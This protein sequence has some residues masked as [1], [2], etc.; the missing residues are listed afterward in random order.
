M[1][2]TVV[3]P[4]GNDSSAGLIVGLVLAAIIIAAAIFLALPYLRDMQKPQEQQP[5]KIDVTI[6][7]PTPSPEPQQPS[8]Y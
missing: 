7:N 5:T 6:P 4:Q 1:A 2:T 3:S 8:G